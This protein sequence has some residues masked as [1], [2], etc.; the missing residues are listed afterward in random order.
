[1]FSP[2]KH[3]IYT[4]HYQIL[5]GILI[6]LATRTHSDLTLFIE[7]ILAYNHHPS[8]EYLKAALYSLQYIH[9]TPDLGV[10][11]F[12]VSATEP[13]THIL[14][15]FAHDKEA[16]IGVSDPATTSHHNLTGYS[17]TCWVSK[18]ESMTK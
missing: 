14:H 1:M 8:L 12:S 3:F 7:F 13:N 16:Y 5:V 18:L 2:S 17:D 6:W 9:L 4:H 15:P 10:N 11:F